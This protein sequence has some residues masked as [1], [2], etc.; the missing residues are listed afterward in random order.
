LAQRAFVDPGARALVP[1][2]RAEPATSPGTVALAGPAKTEGPSTGDYQY[3]AATG[4]CVVGQFRIVD[5]ILRAVKPRD[6]PVQFAQEHAVLI[7]VQAGG[8]HHQV[9]AIRPPPPELAQ[10]GIQR[11][12]NDPLRSE[13]HTSELQSRFDLVCRLLLEK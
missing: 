10:A 3:T 2:D 12:S 9:A 11:F 4:H 7:A 6:L 5:N 1:E 13:E 8:S